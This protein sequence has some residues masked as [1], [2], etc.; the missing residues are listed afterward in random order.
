MSA[1]EYSNPGIAGCVRREDV[2][3]GCR[4]RDCPNNDLDDVKGPVHLDKPPL[5]TGAKDV[6][7]VSGGGDGTGGGGEETPSGGGDGTEFKTF[8]ACDL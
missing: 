2:D 6:V 4:R 5:S 3:C 8:K 1:W 7:A